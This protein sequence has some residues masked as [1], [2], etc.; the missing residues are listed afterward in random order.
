MK[1]GWTWASHSDEMKDQ[2]GSNTEDQ[3]ERTSLEKE[4]GK[5]LF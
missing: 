3:F 1:M 2:T 5:M 4:I